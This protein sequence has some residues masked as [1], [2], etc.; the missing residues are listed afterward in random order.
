MIR[1]VFICFAVLAV[2]TV[3]IPAQ[4]TE[5]ERGWNQPVEPFRIAGNIYYVGASD[6]TSYL[7][8]TPKGHILIDSGFI[9]TVPQIKANIQ[10]LGFKLEDVK[11]LLNSHAHYDHAGGLAEL[12]RLTGARLTISEQ[13]AE[14]LA[15]G[16]VKDPNFGDRF[17]FEGVGA[18]ETFRDGKKIK[19]GGIT[20]TANITSGHTRGCTTWTTKVK[21]K[22]RN[23]NAI[24][25]CSTSAPGYKLVG[26][27]K[28]PSIYADYLKT[29]ARL[30]KLKPD[31][32]LGSHGGFFDLEAKIEKMK[33]NSADNPFVDPSGY[34]EYLKASKASLA[35]AYQ[36]QGGK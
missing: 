8:T 32:F 18:D 25:V 2:F 10:K 22:G 33:S 15:N 14:L 4:K 16:G 11:I 26:N 28:Y 19:L 17:E 12:K 7:I 34:Q 3:H 9:E 31:I 30:E 6:I 21:D 35:V 36:K 24:F 27:E 13:D 20:M 23:L 1:T 29:F 5:Q